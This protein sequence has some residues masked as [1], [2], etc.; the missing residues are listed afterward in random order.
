MFL[1]NEYL[2]SATAIAFIVWLIARRFP[3][4]RPF[5]AATR[6]VPA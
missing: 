3:L 4:H 2:Y 5:I 1:L 6:E